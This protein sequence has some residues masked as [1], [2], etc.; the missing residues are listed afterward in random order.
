MRGKLGK[1]AYITVA[2]NRGINRVADKRGINW[3]A[4]NQEINK[5]YQKIFCIFGE[6]LFWKWIGKPKTRLVG[7]N[8]EFWGGG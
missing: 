6:K 5:G 8:V 2:V 1:M 3:V 4:D 7:E